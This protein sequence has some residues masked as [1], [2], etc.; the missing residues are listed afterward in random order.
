MSFTAF[1]LVPFVETNIIKI[2]LIES[3]FFYFTPRSFITCYDQ[4]ILIKFLINSMLRLIIKNFGSYPIEKL[5]Y[6]LL[7]LVSQS[8]G[9]YDQRDWWAISLSHHIKHHGQWLNSLTKT[10]IIT[11]STIHTIFAKGHH[12]LNALFL[13][14]P[15]FYVWFIFQF[16]KPSHLGLSEETQESFWFIKRLSDPFLIISKFTLDLLSQLWFR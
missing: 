7:P 11:Q 3:S 2:Y 13:I 12:P 10:H 15:E 8:V 9:Y 14:F 6:L 5:C 1:D 4:I 16:I